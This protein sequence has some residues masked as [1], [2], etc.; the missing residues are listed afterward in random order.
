VTAEPREILDLRRRSLGYVSQFLRVV[1]RV[2]TL[3]V[4]AEPLLIN[5]E[6]TDT[7]RERA[8]EM[9]ARLN[10][11]KRLWQLSPTTFSGGEQQ[12]VNVA[13]G[14]VYP[15][16]ALLL[17]EPTASLD[18]TNR[19]V[20]LSLIEEAKARGTAIVGIFHDEDARDR[21]ADRELDVTGFAPESAA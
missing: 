1:P 20:V 19:E 6:N 9:L 3:D 17:D 4:V 5:G 14:F 7:A 8:A 16:P 18:G 11:P 13:R 15:F 10:L 12:R 21:V 2:P